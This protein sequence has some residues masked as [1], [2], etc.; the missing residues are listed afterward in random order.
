[1]HRCTP[2]LKLLAAQDWWRETMV[3]PKIF[4][5]TNLLCIVFFVVAVGRAHLS[6]TSHGGVITHYM[7]SSR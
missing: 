4:A 1:M 3:L 6:G 2:P 7:L 5:V